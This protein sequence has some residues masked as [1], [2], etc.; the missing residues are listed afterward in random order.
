MYTIFAFTVIHFSSN[1]KFKSELYEEI[2]LNELNIID[3]ANTWI[4]VP[5]LNM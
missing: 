3:I 4:I 5:K 2:Q 1:L